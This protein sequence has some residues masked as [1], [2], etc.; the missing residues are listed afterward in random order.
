MPFTPE[1]WLSSDPWLG[2]AIAMLRLYIAINAKPEVS[3][4][5][6]RLVKTYEQQHNVN[7]LQRLVILKWT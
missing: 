7:Q 3:T 2:S 1:Q 5:M 6:F 4:G